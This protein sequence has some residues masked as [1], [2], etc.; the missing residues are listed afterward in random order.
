M[1]LVAFQMGI[2]IMKEKLQKD[3]GVPRQ[4]V[5]RLEP[6]SP[7]KHSH[8][9]AREQCR[10]CCLGSLRPW[11]APCSVALAGGSVLSNF[12]PFTAAVQLPSLRSV[13]F[14]GVTAAPR[15]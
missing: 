5:R 3:P 8:Q 15:L 4:A 13:T 1:Q 9:T 11:A 2:K 6:H 7:T 10:R 14:H 12:I